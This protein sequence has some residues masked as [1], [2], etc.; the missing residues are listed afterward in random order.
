MVLE[1]VDINPDF[2]IFKKIIEENQ[3]RPEYKSLIRNI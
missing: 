3:W 2:E 1:R